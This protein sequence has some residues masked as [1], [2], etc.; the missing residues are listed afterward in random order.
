[1]N[2]P[3]TI[4][5]RE[6]AQLAPSDSHA[7]RVIVRRVVNQ[8]PYRVRGKMHHYLFEWDFQLQAHILDIPQSVWMHEFPESG[9]YRDNR[10]IAHDLQ[11]NRAP[12]DAPLVF[13]LVPWSGYIA[14]LEE[15]SAM[16]TH[17]AEPAL[18]SAPDFIG[19]IRDMLVKL[20]AP[21]V[22]LAAL[23]LATGA[24]N[25]ALLDYVASI[26]DTE[27]EAEQ[28]AET[29]AELAPIAATASQINP[30][31]GLPYT[32]EALRMRKYRAGKKASA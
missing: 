10:S 22:V 14:N 23:D 28:E 26:P 18:L 12:T 21:D 4:D 29:E 20:N 13:L 24:S 15:T 17:E 32:P 3:Q 25:A 7:M 1:M 19:P 2:L 11:G 9:P 6:I 8:A 31:T 16:P 30:K 27:T 5:R